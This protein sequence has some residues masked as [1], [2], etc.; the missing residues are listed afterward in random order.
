MNGLIQTGTDLD[1]DLLDGL[2]LGLSGHSGSAVVEIR[3]VD[4]SVCY[5][6]TPASAPDPNPPVSRVSR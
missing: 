4:L 6:K 1:A 5:P 3:I 2:L